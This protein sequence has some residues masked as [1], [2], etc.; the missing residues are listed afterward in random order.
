M[1]LDLTALISHPLVSSTIGGLIGATVAPFVNW[2]IEKKRL[3]HQSR[4][5][6]VQEWRRQ[7]E[8][9][10]SFTQLHR[11]LLWEELKPYLTEVEQ[12]Q[13]FILS[14]TLRT[15]QSNGPSGEERKL[16]RL[17]EVVAKIEKEWGI[18]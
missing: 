10:G 7:L 6:K 11:S 3:L 1:A 2:Q 8:E 9:V 13:M 5:E 14:V 17:L 15:E 18:I 12:K 16:V 4:K